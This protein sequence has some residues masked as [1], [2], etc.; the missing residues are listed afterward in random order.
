MRNSRTLAPL[1][2]LPVVAIA[3]VVLPFLLRHYYIDVLTMLLIDIILVTSFRLV[4]TTGGWSL[5]HVPLMGAGAYASALI[6][7]TLGWPFWLSLPLSAIAALVIGLIMSYP[8]ARTKGFAFFIASYAAG[9]AMRLCWTRFRVPFGGHTGLTNIPPPG[10][11][12][13]ID[14]SRPVPYYFLALIVTAVCLWLMYRLGRSRIGA[15]FHAVHSQESLA[16]SI[17]INITRYKILVFVVA[18][19]FAGV[20]GVLLVHRMWAIEPNQF[21]FVPTLYV[22]VWVVFGGTRTFVG[23][24]LGVSVLTLLSEL[25][26]PL[27]EWVPM[28]YGCILI[29]TLLFFPEGLEGIPQRVLSLLRRARTGNEL[30]E[31]LTIE[32]H[33]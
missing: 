17:G 7:G 29:L 30:P 9:E 11:I 5:A 12:G 25:L 8:L 3:G 4:T 26:L 20:A 2:V 19:F 18:A 16:K 6:T 32:G 27:A 22:L 31:D 21:G 28:I 1:I 10:N 23:P 33:D 14:F 15:T 24:I 13:A